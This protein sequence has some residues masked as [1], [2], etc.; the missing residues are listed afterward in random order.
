MD[1]LIDHGKNIGMDE[2]FKQNEKSL[3]LKC[4]V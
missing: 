1:K 3:K 4:E 2:I